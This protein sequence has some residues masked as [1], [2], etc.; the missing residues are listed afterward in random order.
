MKAPQGTQPSR[1]GHVGVLMGGVSGERAVSL[2][3]G[4]RVVAALHSRGYHVTGI[5]W[6]GPADNLW[7]TLLQ[8]RIDVV[9]VALHGTLG[10]DGCVQGLLECCGMP[11]TGSS[12]LASALAMDK[13]AARRVFDEEAIESPRWCV[14][15]GPAD[16][17][18]I[19][20]PLIVK[21][22]K[23]GSSLGIS[24]VQHPHEVA[25]ALALAGRCHGSVLLEEFVRGREIQVA[26][27]DGQILGEVEVTSAAPFLDYAAKYERDDTRYQVPA[28]LTDAERRLLHGM[29]RRTHQ[30]LGC[31]GLTRT[32][33]VLSETGR[34]VCLELD[35]LPGLTERSLVPKIAAHAQIDY[36]TLCERVLWGAALKESA[37]RAVPVA[38]AAGSVENS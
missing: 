33:F 8:A 7:E 31:A 5:D 18:K 11:Y 20:L 6:R 34:A 36:P 35:T 2:R 26:V 30:A 16:V 12:V 38:A 4:Q 23:E 24:L 10:E 17:A 13:V 14:Y 32:D 28:K 25:A 3:S 21:P 1:I 22:S 37:F 15:R 19:G 29:A 9:F 27:L